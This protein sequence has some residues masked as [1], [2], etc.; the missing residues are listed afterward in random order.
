MLN[1]STFSIKNVFK[2]K[3][4]PRNSSGSTSDIGDVSEEEEEDPRP[5]SELSEMS[6]QNGVDTY[7]NNTNNVSF[8]N[9]AEDD[10][11]YTAD[12]QPS[13]KITRSLSSDVSDYV[14]Q[15]FFII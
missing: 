4:L 9:V 8:E 14:E 1:L 12:K 10:D 6:S 15:Y 13:S 2:N 11:V 3:K 7:S 5:V